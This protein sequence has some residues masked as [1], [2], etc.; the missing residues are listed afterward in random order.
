MVKA[1]ERSLKCKSKGMIPVTRDIE[2]N[3]CLIYEYNIF[4]IKIF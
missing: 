3:V 4:D 1:L 2:I